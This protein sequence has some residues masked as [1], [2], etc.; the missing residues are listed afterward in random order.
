MCRQCIQSY[1]VT[2]WSTGNV[3]S[4]AKLQTV[5]LQTPT[6]LTVEAASWRHRNDKQ[7]ATSDYNLRE[8]TNTP[9]TV[10]VKIH[11]HFRAIPR[12]SKEQSGHDEGSDWK[13]VLAQGQVP[14]VQVQWQVCSCSG[15]DKALCFKT[16][17]KG[18]SSTYKTSAH[19][20]K[21]ST[22]WKDNLQ[23]GRSIGNL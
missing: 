2:Q 19:G 6:V 23:N 16:I 8:G 13:G 10:H 15:K 9:R 11:R 12:Q 7:A 4:Q 21:S 5:P 14:L 22:R 17:L 3:Q 1:A 20:K 18:A